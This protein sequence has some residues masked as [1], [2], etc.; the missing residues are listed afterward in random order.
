M[1]K[2]KTLWDPLKEHC[3]KVLVLYF[4]NEDSPSY[5]AHSPSLR[6]L[7]EIIVIYSVNFFLSN[8]NLM[9]QSQTSQHM[10]PQLFTLLIVE[11]LP[12]KCSEQQFVWKQDAG[13][14]SVS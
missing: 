3:L 10:P 14:T 13:V 2:D 8:V 12:S 1:F 7:S 5:F 9:L 11:E 6:S 4:F